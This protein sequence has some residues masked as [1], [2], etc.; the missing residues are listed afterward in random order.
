MTLQFGAPLLMTLAK[1]RIINYDRNCSFIVLATVI[2]IV[3]YNCHLYIVQ[4][5]DFSNSKNFILFS[6]TYPWS[7]FNIRRWMFHH[8]SRM[9]TGLE[10]LIWLNAN[11]MPCT[12]AHFPQPVS[13]WTNN[14][15][16]SPTAKELHQGTLR[17]G[18]FSVQLT[19]LY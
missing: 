6:F 9:K 3:N 1:A 16:S 10:L 7:S 2:T 13:Y 15:I 8:W 4:A 14:A 5:T 17:K 11:F 12:Q 18:K 19:S